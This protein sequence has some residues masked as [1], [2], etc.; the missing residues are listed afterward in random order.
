MNKALCNLCKP[1]FEGEVN[2]DKEWDEDQAWGMPKH[3]RP[4]HDSIS[5]LAE[6]GQNRCLLCAALWTS[7]AQRQDKEKWFEPDRLPQSDPQ[8]SVAVNL[9]PSEGVRTF[10]IRMVVTKCDIEDKWD[11]T[12]YGTLYCYRGSLAIHRRLICVVI[13]SS[14][15]G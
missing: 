8:I 12:F 1:L 4:H 6:C 7:I 10:T 15:A 13:R 11:I 14:G 5:E 2:I 3:A 9:D